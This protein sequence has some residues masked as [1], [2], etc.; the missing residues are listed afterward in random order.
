MA[1][2]LF[3]ACLLLLIGKVSFRCRLPILI[4]PPC[5]SFMYLP[6]W[7]EEISSLPQYISLTIL[8][9][10]AEMKTFEM[11]ILWDDDAGWYKKI[12]VYISRRYSRHMRDA[13]QFSPA[14]PLPRVGLSKLK[15]M[16]LPWVLF[17]FNAHGRWASAVYVSH[18]SLYRDVIFRERAPD[19]DVNWRR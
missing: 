17:L 11:I 5:L 12:G 19:F 18:F 4:L 1:P 3:I 13:A 2:L 15:S 9:W 16:I 14:E 8:H 6:R 10:A 7:Q